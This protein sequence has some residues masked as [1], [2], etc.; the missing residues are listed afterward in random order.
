[1]STTAPAIRNL[2]RRLLAGEPARVESS[3]GDVHPV[4]RACERLRV[5]LTNLIGVAGFA[6]L[7]SRALALAK[8]QA[9]SLEGLRVE[10]DGLLAGSNEVPQDSDALEGARHGGVV[11]VAELLGLLVTFIGEPLTLSLVREAW[12]DALVETTALSNEE[13]A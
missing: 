12:P 1:M 10:A 8:R 11:L 9:P 13:T 4:V 3:H 7:L 2:A 5:P 6:S